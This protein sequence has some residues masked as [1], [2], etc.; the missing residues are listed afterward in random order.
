VTP[1]AVSCEIVWITLSLSLS[2]FLILSLSLTPLHESLPFAL[3]YFTLVVLEEV[4][5]AVMLMLDKGEAFSLFTLLSFPFCDCGRR[6]TLMC[7][8]SSSWS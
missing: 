4:D 5:G 6:G 8:H 2:F 1:F 7:V 3:L